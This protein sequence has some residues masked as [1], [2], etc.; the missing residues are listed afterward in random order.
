LRKHAP[1]KATSFARLF[2]PHDTHHA[3]CI[4]SNDRERDLA[5]LGS[6][7]NAFNNALASKC[8]G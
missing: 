5:A 3:N 1:I 7:I 6:E 4:G 2:T 8:G